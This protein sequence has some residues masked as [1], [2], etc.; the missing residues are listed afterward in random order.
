MD[1][2]EIM[3]QLN[4]QNRLD[5]MLPLSGI[6]DPSQKAILAEAKYI[7]PYTKSEWETTYPDID[8]SKIY[9][10]QSHLFPAGLAYLD[11]DKYI[12]IQSMIFGEGEMDIYPNAP[13][14]LRD[15]IE[16]K[17]QAFV[18]KDWITLLL[19]SASEQSGNIIAAL[20]NKMILAEDVTVTLYE[21]FCDYFTFSD[22]G[23]GQLS[24]EAMRKLKSNKPAKC[25]RKTEKHMAKLP[26]IITVYRG[27][28]SKSTPYT[29][30][31]SWSTD[32]QIAVFFASR[33]GGEKARIIEA[34]VKKTNVLEYHSS[35]G[36][37][38][39][40][41]LPDDVFDATATPCVPLEHFRTVISTSLYHK[42]NSSFLAHDVNLT[43]L[44]QE[45]E[46]VYDGREDQN[47]AHD[48]AHSARVLLLAYFIYV[49]TVI[50][51]IKN[52]GPK[53]DKALIWLQKLLCATVYHDTGRVDDSV[54]DSHGARSSKIFDE[55]CGHADE[56]VSFLI[57]YHC[58]HDDTAHQA[59][60]LLFGSH[61]EKDTIWYLYSVLKDAD[62]LDRVRFGIRDLNISLLRLPESVYLVPVAVNLIKF[63]C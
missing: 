43:S 12:Y 33:L 18:K 42:T 36:E 25:A 38:E 1:Y 39:I 4:N 20:L 13:Q 19:D 49:E 51:K 34:K 57:T 41:V 22:C 53:M 24:I 11:L 63:K 23:V 3:S 45:L 27:E 56:V 44:R 9:V 29:K 8:V 5:N 47:A 21:A 31:Y 59:W 50:K 52:N 37:S 7:V 6:T 32:K 48:E 28:G 54:D 26:D 58:L 30:A 2:A 17:E 55:M 35:R 16:R 46:E 15:A 40:I 62:A 14:L 60:E 61:P 10:H